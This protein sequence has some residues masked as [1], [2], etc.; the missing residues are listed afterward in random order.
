MATVSW[1]YDLDPRYG[2]ISIDTERGEG[3][4][5]LIVVD[6]HGFTYKDGKMTPTCICNAYHEN[7]CGCG[8]Y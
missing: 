6:N 7:E 8:L 4:E 1:Q 5:T 2:W 3:K